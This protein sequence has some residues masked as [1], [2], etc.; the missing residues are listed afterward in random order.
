MA[1]SRQ[2]FNQV[3][4]ILK[5]L[6]KRISDARRER[7]DEPEPAPEA[8]QRNGV[9]HDEPASQS[10]GVVGKAQRAVPKA[11]GFG[12]PSSNPAPVPR[13]GTSG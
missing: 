6:D 13:F 2:A 11:T 3:R 1:V 12:G 10:A 8:P 7:S 4:S 9:N 5:E